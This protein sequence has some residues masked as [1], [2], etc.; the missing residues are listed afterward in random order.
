M[1]QE[2]TEM[3]ELRKEIDD[4]M[5]EREN[6]KDKLEKV[7]KEN[8]S[9]KKQITT[10]LKISKGEI[11]ITKALE[12]LETAGDVK[13]KLLLQGMFAEMKENKAVITKLLK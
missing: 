3:I 7:G 8:A 12:D 6:L 13:T 1:T 2:L 11:T 9:L 4:G 10:F 5:V